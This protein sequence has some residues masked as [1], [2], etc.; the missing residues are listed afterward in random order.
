MLLLTSLSPQRLPTRL[1]H[2]G[3]ARLRVRRCGRR[4]LRLLNRCH[5][6]LL[7]A[8]RQPRGSSHLEHLR[9]ERSPQRVALSALAPTWRGSIDTRCGLNFHF[10]ERSLICGYLSFRFAAS[11]IGFSVRTTNR[12]VASIHAP[13]KRGYRKKR[14]SN[15]KRMNAPAPQYNSLASGMIGLGPGSHFPSDSIFSEGSLPSG[16]IEQSRMCTRSSPPRL[17]WRRGALQ[18][19]LTRM[20]RRLSAL[21]LLD[22]QY[23]LRIRD[24]TMP[25][26][27]IRDR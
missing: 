1:P 7:H 17:R 11:L 15:A 26:R 2:R 13:T 20:S 25:D 10:G 19:H 14:M 24:R 21:Q 16:M 9:C 6:E 23:R 8:K 18:V 12:V 5:L 4:R 27:L 3:H 22:L